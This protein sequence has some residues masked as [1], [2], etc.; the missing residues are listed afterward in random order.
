MNAY[1]FDFFTQLREQLP[2]LKDADAKHLET[3][4]SLESTWFKIFNDTYLVPKLESSYVSV[5]I[6]MLTS[7]LQQTFAQ[8][9]DTVKRFVG[10]L[11]QYIENHKGKILDTGFRQQ[12]MAQLPALNIYLPP[13]YPVLT[14]AQ[15]E[16]IEGN[17]ETLM[18]Q[19]HAQIKHWT[20]Q[21]IDSKKSEMLD[22]LKLAYASNKELNR[23][24]DNG[25][26]T[27]NPTSSSTDKKQSN[28]KEL[29]ESLAKAVN[30]DQR[31]TQWQEAETA[32]PK[33]KSTFGN[34]LRE[35]IAQQK[36]MLPQIASNLESFKVLID[37]LHAICLQDA[38]NEIERITRE[39]TAQF[40]AASEQS[41]EPSIP[42]EHGSSIPLPEHLETEP[43]TNP[44]ELSDVEPSQMNA[45]EDLALS[46]A[47]PSVENSNHSGDAAKLL[48]SPPSRLPDLQ[49]VPVAEEVSPIIGTLAD[50]QDHNIQQT[51]ATFLQSPDF[52][53]RMD[54][55]RQ[56]DPKIYQSI[57]NVYREEYS[58]ERL[59]WDQLQPITRAMP[60]EQL[61]WFMNDRKISALSLMKLLNE[62]GAEGDLNDFSDLILTSEMPKT[63]FN[64][65]NP[66][67]QT[68][69]KNELSQ[70]LKSRS[71]QWH[72]V[73]A[74][75]YLLSKDDVN[76]I[77]E[78]RFKSLRDA[79]ERDHE[80]DN[81]AQFIVNTPSSYSFY[82][83]FLK[84]GGAGHQYPREVNQRMVVRLDELL[85]FPSLM[86]TTSSW[87]D[88]GKIN[89]D[90][91]IKESF[92]KIQLIFKEYSAALLPEDKQSLQALLKSEFVALSKIVSEHRGISFFSKPHSEQALIKFLSAPAQSGYRKAL[93]INA[94]S[95]G[96]AAVSKAVELFLD[97]CKERETDT[98]VLQP[99]QIGH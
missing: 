16:D 51:L 95:D 10:S 84:E 5:S 79:G 39:K 29:A 87:I 70:L 54:Y 72:K 71:L 33:S 4:S 60:V 37:E 93:E 23:I 59:S 13:D 17:I 58:S 47:L 67:L 56:S 22:A 7:Q 77:E 19:I 44:L 76:L 34:M 27:Y 61:K 50:R 92:V 3:D 83:I 40:N 80:I 41:N 24:I 68:Q 53:Q 52:V 9:S 82:S 49:E 11:C 91:K 62:R 85:L 46:S 1:E 89:K 18:Q 48:S 31:K 66:S 94:T 98:P 8:H 25:I 69:F 63:I 43:S 99:P 64:Q 81:I 57:L 21:S 12:L 86:I 65:L 90:M 55:M 28:L 15:L 26:T 20:Q 97:R 30:T 6:A 45:M 35:S 14:P 38:A 32:H 75:Y 96:K 88:E 73:E 2:D 78:E 74:F 36:A 42:H